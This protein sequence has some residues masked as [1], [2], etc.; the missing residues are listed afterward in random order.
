M[1]KY[2]VGLLF[3]EDKSKIVLIRKNRPEWQ[4]GLYNGVGGKVEENESEQEAMVREFFEETDSIYY[5]WN[6]FSIITNDNGDEVYFYWKTSCS[7]DDVQTKTDE[8]VS[9]HE[10]ENVFNLPLVH[11]LQW[12]IKMALDKKHK[13][14]NSIIINS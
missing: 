10:I 5:D 7:Y 14:S 6:L 9:V 2:V 1:C 11:N 4:V 12:I 13:F 3:S 8:P